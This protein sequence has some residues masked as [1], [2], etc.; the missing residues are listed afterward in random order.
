[1]NMIAVISPNALSTRRDQQRFSPAV[2]VTLK[3]EK[4]YCSDLWSRKLKSEKLGA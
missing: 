2:C 1:M 4:A 3:P